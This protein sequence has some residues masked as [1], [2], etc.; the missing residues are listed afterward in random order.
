[1]KMMTALLPLLLVVGCVSMP[2]DMGE[3][4]RNPVRDFISAPDTQLLIKGTFFASAAYFAEDDDALKRKA[5]SDA[6]HWYLQ[7][8]GY[9]GT[10]QSLVTTTTINAANILPEPDNPSYALLVGEMTDLYLAALYFYGDELREWID[11][12]LLRVLDHTASRRMTDA[13]P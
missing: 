1:M 5:G 11:D 8:K 6:A 7:S 9:L 2:D 4:P 10:Y 3:G 13:E 12:R